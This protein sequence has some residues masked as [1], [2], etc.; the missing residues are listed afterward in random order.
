MRAAV[1]TTP[2][3]AARTGRVPARSITVSPQRRLVTVRAV[4]APGYESPPLS[5]EV[6]AK[7]EEL[8]LDFERSG[9]KYLSNDARVRSQ[10]AAQ[11]CFDDC[12]VQ[13]RHPVVHLT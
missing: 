3:A 10:L 4:E 8:G 12:N 5:E 7:I 6:A 1:A 9:L 13:C 11:L 2:Q